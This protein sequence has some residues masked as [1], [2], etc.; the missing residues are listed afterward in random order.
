MPRIYVVNEQED[1][2]EG[3]SA[4]RTLRVA[5]EV[6]R[7]TARS[8]HPCTIDAMVWPSTK[9]GIVDAYN[10][11]PHEIVAVEEWEPVAI[12]RAHTEMYESDEWSVRRRKCDRGLG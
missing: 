5:R 3:M 8:G 9:E 6:A 11:I 4:F 10:H 2:T 7:G 12:K 1:G